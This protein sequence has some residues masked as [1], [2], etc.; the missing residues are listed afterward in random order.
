LGAAWIAK[1][2]Y[3]KAIEYFAKVLGSDIKTFG[4]VHPKVA[5]DWNNLG[6]AWKNKGRFA[7]G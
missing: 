4:P 2:Q 5:R 3:D 1:H 7:A 6:L